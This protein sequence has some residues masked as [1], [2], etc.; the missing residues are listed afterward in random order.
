MVIHHRIPTIIGQGISKF[1]PA[2][3]KLLQSDKMLLNK[4]YT[5]FKHKSSIVSGIRHGGLVGSTIGTL[6]RDM[7]NPFMDAQI[8]FSPKTPSNSKN[9]TRRGRGRSCRQ[10]SGSKRRSCY[11]KRYSRSR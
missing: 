2:A 11:R 4:A 9:Q 8:P 6:I 7:E 5:G 1:G 10:F 3:N